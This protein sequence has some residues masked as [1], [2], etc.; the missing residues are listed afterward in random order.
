M[1]RCVTSWSQRI[2]DSRFQ[3][4]SQTQVSEEWIK[5]MK[6]LIIVGTSGAGKTLYSYQ[7]AT[8]E[9]AAMFVCDKKGNGGSTDMNTLLLRAEALY[10]SSNHSVETVTAFIQKKVNDMIA[11]RSQLLRHCIQHY[12]EFNFIQWMMVQLYPEKT[13]QQDV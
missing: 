3:V 2:G 13:L 10:A 1:T 11:F 6:A 5:D 7:R 4:N 12:G 9:Y 8:T